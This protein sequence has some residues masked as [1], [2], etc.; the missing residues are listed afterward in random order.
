MPWSWNP[1]LKRNAYYPHEVKG[2][3]AFHWGMVYN[4][5]R[6]LNCQT[7]TMACKSTWTFSRG[8]EYM[9]WNNVETRP[10]GGYPR[11]WD[12]KLLQMLP[13]GK[14]IFE[15]APEGQ[16]ALGY[17]PADE[18]YRFPNVHDDR[19]TGR[20]PKGEAIVTDPAMGQHHQ[21]WFFYLPRLCNHCKRPACLAACPR[22]AIYKRDE[23]G[24]VLVDQKRCRGYRKCVEACPY[25]RPFYNAFTGISE[26][27]IGCYPRLEQGEVTRCVSACP[28][29]IRLFGNINDPESPVSHFVREGIALPLYPQFGTEPQIYYI[30]PRW[31]PVNFLAQM[32]GNYDPE[33]IRSAIHK[34]VH[35]SKETLA[36]LGLFGST[37]QVIEKY[38]LAGN[39]VRGY[40]KGR[41]VVTV[42]IEEKVVVRSA[43]HFNQT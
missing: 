7:C 14:T 25:K 38:T 1:Q 31:A 42:P 5:N 9:W 24:I 26:K 13:K 23:D 29:R 6:C 19:A 11:L 16:N 3:H 2:D 21:M 28:G 22:N 18:E 8:Q 15:A 32:F 34:Y 30:P 17:L 20:Y 27:C 33:T 40:S 37:Q 4:I 36:L 10:F 41:L 43:D 35:P 12:V 39:E